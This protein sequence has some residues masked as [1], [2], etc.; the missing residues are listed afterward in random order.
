MHESK[1]CHLAVYPETSDQD[2]GIQELTPRVASI[3]AGN[4]EAFELM[5]FEDVV[6]DGMLHLAAMSAL[7][8]FVE[9]LVASGHDPNH[10]V[11]EY[12]QYIP[13]AIVCFSRLQPWCKIANKEAHLL[14]RQEQTMA[15]LGL[16][17]KLDWKCSGQTVLHVA[18]DAGQNVTKAIVGVLDICNDV[19]RDV[20]YLY[21]DKDGIHFSPDQYVSRLMQVDKDE[22]NALLK[23]LKDCN[24]MSRYYRAVEPLKGT[25]PEGYHGLP[26]NLQDAWDAHEGRGYRP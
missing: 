8:K 22:K 9:L 19:E 13:L 17:T 3:Y 20:R 4:F 12:G 23:I 18:F 24:L 1:F 21:V 16:K 2:F 25:Q 6:D 7:P 26:A 11:L 10:K 5:Q 15:I 14:T